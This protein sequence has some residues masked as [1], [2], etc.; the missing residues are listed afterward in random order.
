MP[1]SYA[2]RLRIARADV[3]A[4][5]AR[6]GRRVFTQSQLKEILEAN[7]AFWRMGAIPIGTF[8]NLLTEQF[9]CREI[10]IDFPSRAA[11]RY[12]WGRATDFEIIQ[13]INPK[14]YF[15][16]YTAVRLHDLTLQLPKIAYFNVEQ[17]VR[18]GGGVLTQQAI[19]NT[20]TRG[21][22]R[23]SSNVAQFNDLSICQVNG[24]NT[25]NLGVTELVTEEGA[26]PIRVT[27]LERTLIDAAVRPIYAGGVFEVKNA[28]A[29][30][31]DRASINKLT[32]YLK[33][34]GYTYPYHQVIGFYMER[35]GYR[36]S[37]I[38]LLR[39]FPQ[40]YDF[41][42]DYGLKQP[43]YDPHW[44]LYFPKGL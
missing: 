13:S 5:F 6:T 4:T 7:R 16:H 10:R 36:P 17:K 14:G 23:V 30:A 19:R 34:I 39:K 31:K 15:S 33:T 38:A 8:L 24:G 29:A 21:Q 40:K 41:Y 35:T 25:D 37:Q 26:S 9:E 43:E 42:I 11:I 44:K 2:R 20:F 12:V 18:P 22:S 28:Y 32:S 3:E 27:N 1:E